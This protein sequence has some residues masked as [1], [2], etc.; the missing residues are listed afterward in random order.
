MCC[1]LSIMH[2]VI[3]WHKWL[4]NV[5]HLPDFGAFMLRCYDTKCY[6][7]NT[8]FVKF[9][10]VYSLSR[11]CHILWHFSVFLCSKVSFQVF[12]MFVLLLNAFIVFVHYLVKYQSCYVCF[13][14]SIM[15][16]L[17]LCH[18]WLHN[19]HHVPDFGACMLRCYDTRCYNNNTAFVKL[20]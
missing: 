20:T 12:K 10:F 16:L 7:N 9:W 1:F 4:H 2:L 15:H 11:F 6:N 3:F 13:F 18:Y 19:V 8:A 5:H 17:L 14:F